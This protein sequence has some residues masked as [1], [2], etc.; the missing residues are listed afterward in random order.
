MEGQL[1]ISRKH[2]LRH[3]YEE[4]TSAAVLPGDSKQARRVSVGV[5]PKSCSH[6]CRKCDRPEAFNE[7][8]ECER[9]TA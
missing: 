3:A 9:Q 6:G 4:L 5:L 2:E 1:R 8:H 7:D